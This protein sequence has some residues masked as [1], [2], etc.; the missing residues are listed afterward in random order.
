MVHALCVYSKIRGQDRKTTITIQW[1]M[2]SQNS[3]LFSDAFTHIHT[4]A[5]KQTN[6][7]TTDQVNNKLGGKQEHIQQVRKGKLKARMHVKQTKP[8]TN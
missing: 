7:Q 2:H 5:H 6:K 8:Q 1:L 3:S 4:R